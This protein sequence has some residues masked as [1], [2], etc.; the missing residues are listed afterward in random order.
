MDE[1]L[2][3][4]DS[5]IQ[6]KGLFFID[7]LRAGTVVMRLGGRLV[8]SQELDSLIAVAGADPAAPYVDTLTIYEDAHLVLPPGTPI[9]YGNHSCDPTLWH[10]GP[11]ELA[12]RLD[13]TAG[14]QADIDYPAQPATA[15]V[16]LRVRRPAAGS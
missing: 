11:Y 6:G 7:D 12:T 8:N 15:G 13:V 5:P 2:V 1:R 10:V 3:V 16:V 14:V 4:R 9:H